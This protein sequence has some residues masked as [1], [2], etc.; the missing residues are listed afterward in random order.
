MRL[1]VGGPLLF[2]LFYAAWRP[3][4]HYISAG[5]AEVPDAVLSQI[6]LHTSSRI[7]VDY[8]CWALPP[9]L[10]GMSFVSCGSS[11]FAVA[12]SK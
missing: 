6:S 12:I 5:T 2:R 7:K 4:V 11:Q 9:A 10:H 3:F 1:L 8:P